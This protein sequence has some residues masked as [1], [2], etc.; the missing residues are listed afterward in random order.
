[1]ETTVVVNATLLNKNITVAYKAFFD[2][3]ERGARAH[4]PGGW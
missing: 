2:P 3:L 1:M 4:F